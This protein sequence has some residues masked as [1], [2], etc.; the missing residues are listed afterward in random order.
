MRSIV[1]GVVAN[2]SERLRRTGHTMSTAIVFLR[3]L[4]TVILLVRW[5]KLQFANRLTEFHEAAVIVAVV[6]PLLIKLPLFASHLLLLS[7][8]SFART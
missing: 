5:L 3:L 8:R 1:L 4:H 2:L 6:V 7:E